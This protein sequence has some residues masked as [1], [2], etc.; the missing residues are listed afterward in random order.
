[1]HFSS[2]H[3]Y[4]TDANMRILRA[5]TRLCVHVCMCACA[6][7]SH[8]LQLPHLKFCRGHNANLTIIYSLKAK[9]KRKDEQIYCSRSKANTQNIRQR[10]V[11]LCAQFTCG[12]IVGIRRNLKFK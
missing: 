3:E 4:G 9:M 7:S 8:G 12:N 5:H 10:T 2:L 11:N 1:M 6:S